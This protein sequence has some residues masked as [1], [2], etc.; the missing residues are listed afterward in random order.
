[1][2]NTDP[3]TELRRMLEKATP[4]PW[5]QMLHGN[6]AYPF[7]LTINT[8]DGENW[9]ARDGYAARLADAALIVA[10][11]NALPVLLNCAEALQHIKRDLAM[12]MV[13]TAETTARIAL[14]R[15]EGLNP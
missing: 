4:G 13:Q 15:L 7:P 6:E 10:A 9:V 2:A 11:V 5:Q 3:L 12:G 1:M 8:A 14:A